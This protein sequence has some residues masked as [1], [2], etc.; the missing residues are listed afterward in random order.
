MHILT[1]LV[2]I[3]QELGLHA[4]AGELLSQELT[5]DGFV[6]ILGHFVG[7]FKVDLLDKLL[8]EIFV[9]VGAEFFRELLKV[10]G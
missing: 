8:D 6:L 9:E 7:V 4:H 5:L 2:E 10:K 1:H 3:S